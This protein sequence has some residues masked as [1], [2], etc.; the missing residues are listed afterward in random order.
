[1]ARKYLRKGVKIG[2]LGGL[3]KPIQNLAKAEFPP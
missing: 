2:D 3:G 1:M